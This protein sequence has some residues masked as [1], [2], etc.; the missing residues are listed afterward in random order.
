MLAFS[1]SIGRAYHR[2][3]RDLDQSQANSQRFGCAQSVSLNKKARGHVV[4]RHFFNFG[5]Q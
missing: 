4:S 1:G 3:D 5:K 2:L